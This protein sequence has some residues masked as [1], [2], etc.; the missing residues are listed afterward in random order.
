MDGEVLSPHYII[1]ADEM[2]RVTFI[3]TLI[4]RGNSGEFVNNVVEII[5]QQG[6]QISYI[7]LQELGINTVH[8]AFKRAVVKKDA[9]I[10]WF[11]IGFG[12]KISNVNV[13]TFLTE[14]GANAE[15]LGLYFAESNQQL[16]YDTLQ[17]HKAPNCNSDLLY[18][19][20]LRDSAYTRFNGVIR[21]NKGSQKTNAYQANKNLILSQSAHVDTIP[22]LEIEANDVRCTHGAT[23]GPISAEDLFYLTSRGIDKETAIKLLAIGFFSQVLDRIEIEDLK[24]ELVRYI[25]HHITK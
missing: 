9:S 18:K 25:E 4:G 12:S 2:S 5:A 7:C 13:E 20:A 17:L 6:A 16:E 24:S 10:R 15:L 11:E 1:I 22:Q 21:V 14:S 19:G 8:S 3:D 23:V